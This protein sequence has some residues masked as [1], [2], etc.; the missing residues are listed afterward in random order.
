MYIIYRGQKIR[1]QD[2]DQEFFRPGR[3]AC[4]LF[5]CDTYH[6]DGLEPRALLDKFKYVP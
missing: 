5:D 1:Q 3:E 4:E 6:D 2:L